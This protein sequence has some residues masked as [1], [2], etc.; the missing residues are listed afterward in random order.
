[1]DLPVITVGRLDA[2][3]GEQI[4]GAG[5]AD[6]IA[7]GRRLLADPEYP[8]K[9]AESRMED[10]AP[11]TADLECV[12]RIATGYPIRCRINA[13]LGREKEYPLEPA[14]RKK[15]VVIVG[16][17]PGGM[18][19]ARVAALRGHEVVL[20]EKDRRLGG[21][22]RLAAMVKGT[23][24]ED[25]PAIIAYLE[26]QIRKLGVRVNL[27]IEADAERIT[28]ERPDAVVLA[29]GGRLALPD[30]PGCRTPLVVNHLTLHRRA[31]FFLR[32]VGPS[33]LRG[34]T[35]FYLPIGQRVIIVGG[36]IQGCE[37]GEFLIKRG[38]RVTILEASEKM[39]SG[40]PEINRKRVLFWLAK[41]GAH[42]LNGVVYE[43]ISERGI[44]L[45]TKEG[46]RQTLEAD[47]ILL[48][49]P[50][51]P[52]TALF[53]ALKGKVPQVYLI[54]DAKEPQDIRLAIDDGFTTAYSL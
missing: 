53:G 11:C 18:E 43:E 52:N 41:N 25:L 23:D 21:L 12:S 15:K 19:A 17:G 16:G 40:I 4:L 42:L 1:V 10:I 51:A 50:T 33:V 29:A 22:L 30:I 38:R 32:F 20:Y 27:E 24:V 34:L 36:A 5:K 28:S 39:G 7:M 2:H 13:R 46:E 44:T 47:T 49:I 14:K 54:G 6:L 37:I 9:V 26:G 3:A 45:I 31:K 35:R 8:N 48:A